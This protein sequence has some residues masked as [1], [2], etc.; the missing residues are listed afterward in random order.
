MCSFAVLLFCV[1]FL[2]YA[3]AQRSRLGVRYV[4]SSSFWMNQQTA[5]CSKVR[6]IR[7]VPP[8]SLATA[9]DGRAGPPT[10]TMMAGDLSGRAPP[11]LARPFVDGRPLPAFPA[12]AA[13]ASEARPPALCS[14]AVSGSHAAAAS[15]ALPRQRAAIAACVPPR[16]RSGC[17]RSRTAAHPRAAGR[18]RPPPLRRGGTHR[19]GALEWGGKRR[20]EERGK[21][22]V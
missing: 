8:Q 22:Q 5:L 21:W 3:R 15:D 1:F 13:A 19:P 14:A 16:R 2:R 18:D 7:P 10:A 12:S 6:A 11:D 4:C 17:G 9:D 20:A